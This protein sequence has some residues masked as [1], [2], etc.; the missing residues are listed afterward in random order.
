MTKSL[1]QLFKS[2]RKKLGLTQKQVADKAG[3]YSNTYARIERGVQR[4][5]YDNARR[6]ARVLGVELPK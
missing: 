5:E 6:I 2:T 3:I 4:P 1:P